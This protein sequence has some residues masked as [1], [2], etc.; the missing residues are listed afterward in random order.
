MPTRIRHL[1]SLLASTLQLFRVLAVRPPLNSIKE[2]G[3][4]GALRSPP[5][6]QNPQLQSFPQLSTNNPQPKNASARFSFPR[7]CPFT[8][9][10]GV[11]YAPNKRE[12]DHR[13]PL[14]LT[15]RF[16][17]LCFA[18]GPLLR[19]SLQRFDCSTIPG[20]P[21][22]LALSSKSQAAAWTASGVYRFYLPLSGVGIS[23]S[24]RFRRQPDSPA[25]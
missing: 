16:P 15:L 7:R 12:I 1:L 14:A 17:A 18:L 24:R 22:L 25:S 4:H 19:T 10:P 2:R 5:S 13:R 6:T 21:S 8:T 11:R 23:P 20:S 3:S 9:I